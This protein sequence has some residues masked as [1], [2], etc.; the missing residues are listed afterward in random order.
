MMDFV[1]IDTSNG[2]KTTNGESLSPAALTKAAAILTVFLNRDV[3]SEWGGAHSVRAGSSITDVLPTECPVDSQSTL[4]GVPGAIAYHDVTSDGAPVAYDGVSLSDSLFGSSNSWLGAI[5]HELAETIVDAGCNVVAIDSD[6]T[7]K[8]QEACDPVEE[9]SYEILLPDGITGAYVSNFITR[10]YFIPNSPAP[11][12]FISKSGR[13][14]AIPP[15]S[16]MQVAP[17]NGGNYQ[18]VYS[19]IGAASQVTATGKP[20]HRMAKKAHPLSRTAR[21]G[22]KVTN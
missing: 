2:A 17:A 12:D 20:T 15:P 7:A 14:G 18:I 11:Y 16:P 3:A 13:P 6:G 10:N 1:L 21:R 19:S 22:L 4:V 8:A 5:S 9:Q